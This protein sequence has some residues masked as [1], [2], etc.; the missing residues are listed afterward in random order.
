MIMFVRT[1]GG[2]R[3]SSEM[4]FVGFIKRRIKVVCHILVPTVAYR[5]YA[6]FAHASLPSNTVRA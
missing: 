4:E 2:T 6:A 3:A 1:I 5:A